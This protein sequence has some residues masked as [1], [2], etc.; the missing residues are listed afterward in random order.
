MRREGPWPPSQGG[1]HSENEIM[2]RGSRSVMIH[3][4]VVS[5]ICQCLTAAVTVP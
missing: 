1:N 3:V 5:R 2:S 4:N